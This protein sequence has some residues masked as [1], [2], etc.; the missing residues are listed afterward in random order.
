[1]S[2]SLLPALGQ[3][4][5]AT[6]AIPANDE[7]LPGAGP[8][9]RYDWFKKLWEEKRTG[10]AK[11]VEQDQGAVVFLGDSITQGWGDDLGKAFGDLKWANRGISGDTTRGMLLRLK[12]DVLS[13]KPRAV[14]LLMGTNDLEEKAEPE[15]IVDNL[16]LIVAELKKHNSAM[17]IILC[18]VFPS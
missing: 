8:I 7:G 2:V 16:K 14:V 13:L 3:E 12:E 17:P 5:K 9:R 10:W 11:R 18:K 1:A 15:T 6:F 4:A